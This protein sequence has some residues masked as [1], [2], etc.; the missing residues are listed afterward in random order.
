MELREHNRELVSAESSNRITAPDT[1]LEARGC[2]LQQG[3]TRIMTKGVIHILEAVQVEEQ[4]TDATA[5]LCGL[6]ES[7][8]EPLL[9]ESAVRQ[10]RE[11]IVI[12]DPPKLRLRHFSVCDVEGY[13]HDPVRSC[14]LSTRSQPDRLAIGKQVPELHR[15]DATCADPVNELAAREAVVWMDP[16]KEL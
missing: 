1:A 5:I 12:G 11:R 7:L 9:K 15:L 16:F 14:L 6:V 13:S 2:P 10:A 4:K 3:I 8:V